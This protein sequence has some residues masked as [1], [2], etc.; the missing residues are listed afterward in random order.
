M[1]AQR[2]Q[3]FQESFG[4]RRKIFIFFHPVISRKHIYMRNGDFGA[5]VNHNRPL[6]G[7]RFKRPD[8][9]QPLADAADFMAFG[10]INFQFFFVG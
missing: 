5:I 6:G 10:M 3:M 9:A 8:A 4:L 1:S 2:F 7:T